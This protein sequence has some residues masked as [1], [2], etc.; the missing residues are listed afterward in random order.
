MLEGDKMIRKLIITLIILLQPCILLGEEV[1]SVSLISLIANPDKYDSKIVRVEG[2]LHIKF[3]DAALYLSKSDADY[4]N[5]NNAV[6]VSFSE[7]KDINIQPLD[8]NTKLNKENL[9][10][11]DCKYV[12]LEGTFNKNEHGH[13]GAYAATLEDVTRIMESTQWYDGKKQLKK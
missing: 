2:Y 3:E 13:M 4:L 10:Y 5:G 6:W 1:R 7:K 12:L 8:R 11:F 9:D